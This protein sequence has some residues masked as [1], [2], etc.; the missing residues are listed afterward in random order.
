ML[1][2]GLLSIWGIL[3]LKKWGLYL[4]FGLV[5]IIQIASILLGKWSIDKIYIPLI[6]IVISTFYFKRFK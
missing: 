5:F 2:V 1:L 6:F 3:I 4:Y